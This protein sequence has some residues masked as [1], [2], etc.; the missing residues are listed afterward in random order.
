MTEMYFSIIRHGFMLLIALMY[1]PGPFMPTTADLDAIYVALGDLLMMLA[2]LVNKLASCTR[3]WDLFLAFKAKE[4][5][6][7]VH[8]QTLGVVDKEEGVDTSAN[9]G[10]SKEDV[11]APFHAAVHLWKAL[12]NDAV[13]LISHAPRGP[14]GGRNLQCPDPYT[15][16]SPRTR[17]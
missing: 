10:C 5:V 1:P 4:L 13:G 16:C 6:H 12:G 14:E 15:C 7:L 9:K 17:N 2:I 8:A 11:D 3:F